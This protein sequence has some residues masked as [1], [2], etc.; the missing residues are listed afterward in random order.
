MPGDCN[1]A[2]QHSLIPRVFTRV[3]HTHVYSLHVTRRST[4]AV[5]CLTNTQLHFSCPVFNKRD[6]NLEIITFDR[7]YYSGALNQAVT[8]HSGLLRSEVSLLLKR[9]QTFRINALH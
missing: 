3:M 8:E 9:C 5:T 2:L 1:I 6:I 4:K 7:R